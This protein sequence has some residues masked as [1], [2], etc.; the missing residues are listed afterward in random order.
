[1]MTR[2]TTQW[3]VLRP[4]RSEYYNVV[5]DTK[6]SKT[7]SQGREFATQRAERGRKEQRGFD[8]KERF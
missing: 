5:N 7:K 4:T 6:N 2:G 1:M 8:A 3:Q